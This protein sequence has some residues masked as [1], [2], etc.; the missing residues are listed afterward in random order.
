MRLTI[1]RLRTLVVAAAVLLLLATIGFLTVGRF[2]NPF[3]TPD[4]PQKLGLNIQQDSKGVT[5]SHALGGHSQFK[6]H[7]SQVVQLKQGN[8]LLHDVQIELYGEDGSRVD[9]IVG[10]EFEYNQKDGTAIA[11][12]PVE[13]TLMRPGVAPAIAPKAVPGQTLASQN[14]PLGSAARAA[15]AG[16]IHVK[17]SGLNFNWKTGIAT[18]TQHVDFLTTQGAGSAQ[19]ATYESK[20]GHLVLERNVALTTQRAGDPV[21]ILAAHAEF[22]RADMICNLQSATVDYRDG[23]AVAKQARIEFRENG[24]AAHMDA[25]NGFQFTTTTGGK[26][27]A[28]H[29]SIEFN[30]RNE[31]QRGRL[32]GGV[33]LDSEQPGRKAHGT[34]PAADLEFTPKGDLRHV[35]LAGG[36]ELASN[37]QNPGTG[38]HAEPFTAHRTW[39]SPMVDVDFRSSARGSVEPA[40]MTGTGGVVVLSQVQHGQ[41][42]PAVAKLTADQVHGQFAPGAQLSQMTGSGHAAMEQTLASGARQTATG[43]RLEAHFAAA[44]PGSG[45]NL[46]VDVASLDGHVVLTQQQAARPGAK[47]EPPLHAFAGHAAYTA[48][49]QWL[50]LT[51]HP[52]LDDSGLQLTADKIDLSEDSGDA[53]AHGNV[54]ATWTQTARSSQHVG[55]LAPSAQEPAHV[56]SNEA[57]LHQAPGNADSIATFRGHARLWQQA[58][59]V[60]APVIV[61]EK[62]RQTL[63]AHS[64]DRSDPVR[65]ILLNQTTHQ[66]ARSGGALPSVIR[67]HGG[68]LHYSGVER[69]A[70]MVGG[71]L[72]QVVAE[73]PSASSQSDQ[74]ELHL[75]PSGKAAA[76][77]ATQGQVERMIARGHLNLNSAGRRGT[78]EQLVYTGATGEYVLT[79]TPSAPPRIV[80]PARGSVTGAALIFRSRDDSVSIEG[81]GR[82][83]TTQTT[84][85]R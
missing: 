16:Q 13:I 36:V 3:K 74:V 38:H 53:F 57:Q 70:V 54:K 48:D 49:G 59:S 55:G 27:Q 19:G 33:I 7:A 71:K 9:H 18:T 10:R 65:V 60:A 8:A 22:A 79:G 50:H 84:A 39:R 41:A 42:A 21:K 29:G 32:D 44:S 11:A 25:T 1:E 63:E 80:D 30:E 51:I 75:T 23:Q 45:S 52:R 81:S 69:T 66:D 26:L 61:L 5:F 47:P 15:A 2:R 43:E 85:P 56:V 40:T 34:A 76:D 12:G 14:S 67:L 37:E 68:D 78:G 46:Q 28:P 82:P 77:P 73:T 24:S 17:T 58:N 20:Q 6:I 64:T 62:N 72:G 31:P 4:M 35:R 83:T